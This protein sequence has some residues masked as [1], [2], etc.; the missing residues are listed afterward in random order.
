[1][2]TPTPSPVKAVLFTLTGGGDQDIFLVPAN[3]LRWCHQV[4]PGHQRLPA[5]VLKALRPFL[6]AKTTAA[7]LQEEQLITGGSSDNDAA[8]FLAG[9]CRRFDTVR[10]ALAHAKKQGWAVADQ[11]YTGYLY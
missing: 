1:M 8:L 2:P 7:D 4:T 5:S 6:A 11:E 10:Q 3:A 9:V